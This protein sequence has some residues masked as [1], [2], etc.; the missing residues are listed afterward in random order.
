M[1]NKKLKIEPITLFSHELKT[2]L[3]SLKLAIHL[4]EKNCKSKKDKELIALMQDEINHMTNFICNHLDLQIIKEKKD[5]INL[6][7]HPWNKIILKVL[8]NFQLLT[9]EKNI[10][11][12]VLSDLEFESFIDPTWLAQALENLLSNAIKFSP[13]NSTVLIDYKLKEEGFECFIT[14]Q[15][16]IENNIKNLFS[17]SNKENLFFLKDTGFGLT[18]SKMIIESHSGSLSIHSNKDKKET[19]I[20]F[21]IPKAQP[22]KKSA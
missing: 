13:K 11:L 15:G 9:L 14:N 5:L 18:I 3:S 22:I 20:S 17:K 19:T 4:L 1:K 10:T 16:E 12:K 8:K 21:F 2:P 7:W 6:E